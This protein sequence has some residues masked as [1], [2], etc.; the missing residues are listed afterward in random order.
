MKRAAA[1]VP[2]SHD[3]H[4]ALEV[5]LRLSRA[6]P[7]DVA[8]AVKRFDDYWQLRGRRHLETEEELVFTR[9]G[10]AEWRRLTT[11]A[12][13]EHARIRELA[14]GLHDQPAGEVATANALGALLHDHVRFEERELFVTLENSL[15]EIELTDLGTA[16]QAAAGG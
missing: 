4:V 15:T 16:L 7:G 10:D 6:D 13:D 8:G 1:L 12:N 5:A 2:L 14:D 3:H 11:R 9:P